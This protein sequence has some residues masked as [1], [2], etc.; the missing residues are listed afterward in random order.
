M[1]QLP[2]GSEH[3]CP[4]VRHLRKHH[5]ETFVQYCLGAGII[6]CGKFNMGYVLYH[7]PN[8][9]VHS[10]NKYID[11]LKHTYIF[12]YTHCLIEPHYHFQPQEIRYHPPNVDLVWQLQKR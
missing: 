1:V 4:Y 6:F 5:M 7:L 8:V 12:V 11:G 2:T 9:P 3:W 10:F